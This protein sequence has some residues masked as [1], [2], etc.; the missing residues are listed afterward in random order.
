MKKT[1]WPAGAQFRD[2][3]LV[4]SGSSFSGSDAPNALRF[5]LFG[6]FPGQIH[7]CGKENSGVF[8][9]PGDNARISC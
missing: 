3:A 5:L 4:G 7:H 8:P 1:D 6:R 2:A 9:K